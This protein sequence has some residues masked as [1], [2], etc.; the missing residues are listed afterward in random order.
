MTKPPAGYRPCVGLALFNPAGLVFVGR[1]ANRSQRE[2]TAPGHEWQM[3]QGGIDAGEQPIEAA[4]RELREETNVSSVSLLAEAPD[5]LSY[6]LPREIGREAWRGKYRG[7]SQKWFAFRFDGDESEIDIQSPGG[8]H[9]PEFDAWRWVPL[10]E[11]AELI[12]PFKRE[13][14]REVV[15]QFAGIA[16]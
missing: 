15:R 7:Q 6:D 8:G 12:I 4:Y 13:V 11:T 3:P 16:R 14:Y 5:W 2:H 10:A 9:K 1:R